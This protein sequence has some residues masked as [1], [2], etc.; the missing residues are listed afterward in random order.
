MSIISASRNGVEEQGVLHEPQLPNQTKSNQP[1]RDF[2]GPPDPH[3]DI[4]A[5]LPVEKHQKAHAGENR[6]YEQC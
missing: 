6:Q 1:Q 5:C 4:P 2:H 3:A